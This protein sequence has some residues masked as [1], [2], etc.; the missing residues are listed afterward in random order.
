MADKGFDIHDLLAPLGVHLNMPPFLDKK[1]QMPTEQVLTTKKIVK[2][3][4]YMKQAIGHE[5]N[6]WILR[7][8]LPVTLWDCVNELVYICCML[9]NFNPPLV[10]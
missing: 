2:L 6:Y 9:T 7:G 4:V 1:R 10:C 8:V 5:K 3:H